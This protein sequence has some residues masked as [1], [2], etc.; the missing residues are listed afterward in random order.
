MD[1]LLIAFVWQE[2]VL[3][4]FHIFLYSIIARNVEIRR[5]ILFLAFS[6]K[7]NQSL[8]RDFGSGVS[9]N[10]KHGSATW[11][12]PLLRKHVTAS[13]VSVLYDSLVDCEFIEGMLE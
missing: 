11:L 13:G 10:S 8:T 6:W 3:I 9:P 2:L 1:L 7:D 12:R 4:N 5:E